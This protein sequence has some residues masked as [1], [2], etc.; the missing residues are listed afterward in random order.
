MEDLRKAQGQRIAFMLLKGH[1]YG[2]PGSDGTVRGYTTHDLEYSTHQLFAV[3]SGRSILVGFSS[4]TAVGVL[5]H[6]LYSI[7]GDP[8]T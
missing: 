4:C 8:I 1:M 5:V 6:R 3:L 7:T 2:L